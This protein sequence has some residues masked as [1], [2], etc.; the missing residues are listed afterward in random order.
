MDNVDPRP[1]VISPMLL[2]LRC[3]LLLLKLASLSDQAHKIPGPQ[4]L[5]SCAA[6][7]SALDKT[8]LQIDS[9]VTDSYEEQLGTSEIDQ[10]QHL[11]MLLM[12][13]SIPNLQACVK[14]EACVK[15]KALFHCKLL[16]TLLSLVQEP[17]RD[18][19]IVHLL[20]AGR[21]FTTIAVLCIGD[22]IT[23]PNDI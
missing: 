19:I 18:A 12:Q 6:L 4:S 1:I 16:W 11:S 21:S 8:R 14:G 10:R 9:H 5:F 13:R 17:G 15:G 20:R 22:D 3:A 7:W 2:E 23:S